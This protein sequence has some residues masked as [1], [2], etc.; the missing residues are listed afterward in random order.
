MSRAEWRRQ[1]MLSVLR[2]LS[3]HFGILD[4]TVTLRLNSS[5]RKTNQQ[6]LEEGLPRVWGQGWGSSN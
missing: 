2:E 6:L 4:P 3:F 5:Q 1:E